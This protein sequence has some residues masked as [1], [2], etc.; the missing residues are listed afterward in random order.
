MFLFF[1]LSSYYSV[2]KSEFQS[3][4]T[5]YYPFY[6]S[7]LPHYLL[8]EPIWRECDPIKRR[9]P[10]HMLISSW[11]ERKLKWK[12][13]IYIQKSHQ[14]LSWRI[15]AKTEWIFTIL[16]III[17]T[18][19]FW[20]YTNWWYKLLGSSERKN[21]LLRMSDK[22]VDVERKTISFSRSGSY[23][24]DSLASWEWG[25]KWSILLL[26]QGMIKLYIIFSF[27]AIRARVQ[28]IWTTFIAPRQLS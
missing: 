2:I 13:Y 9:I 10:L 27:R 16:E 21:F 26:N 23:P 24:F 12:M 28:I 5:V 3:L 6:H 22:R 18:K 25:P 7:Y 20:N 15:W 1:F 11:N 14:N 17:K 4:G 19:L 8:K